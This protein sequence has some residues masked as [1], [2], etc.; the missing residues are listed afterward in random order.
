[1]GARFS[2]YLV[3]C[4]RGSVGTAAPAGIQRFVFVVSGSITLQI[5]KKKHVLEE[6]GYALIPADTEHTLTAKGKSQLN[7]FEKRYIPIKAN[8]TFLKSVI[9]Q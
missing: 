7:I 6:Y 2:Q 9:S 5:G 8:S 3:D 1:M 4:S